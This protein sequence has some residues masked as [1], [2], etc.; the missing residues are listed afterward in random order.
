MNINNMMSPGFDFKSV[1]GVVK[2]V[3]S[4]S[5]CFIIL[6]SCPQIEVVTYYEEVLSS[7]GI[8]YKVS[9][10]VYVYFNEYIYC[11]FFISDIANLI[12]NFGGHFL[13]S[14]L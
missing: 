6:V 1:V 13:I 4:E 2:R 8:L 14:I 11:K 7:F 9:L 5:T 10:F 3:W 12:Y